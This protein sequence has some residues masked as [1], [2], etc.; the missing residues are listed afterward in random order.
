MKG[1]QHVT[2]NLGVKR[3]QV[4]GLPFLLALHHALLDIRFSKF[5]LTTNIIW[6]WPKAAPNRPG[7]SYATLL[8]GPIIYTM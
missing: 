6:L 3:V 7:V 8:F 1:M 5:F 4:F 2:S